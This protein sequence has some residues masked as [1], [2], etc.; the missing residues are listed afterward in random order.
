MNKKLLTLLTLTFLFSISS[1]ALAFSDTEGHWAE[2]AIV[3]AEKMNI[4]NGYSDDTFKPDEP[5]TRAELVAVINRL[6]VI[7]SETDKYVPDVTR[8]DWFH[9]D[10]RK[11]MTMG[12]IQG[13][14]SGFVNPNSYVTREQAALIMAR[15][16]SVVPNN[17]VVSISFTDEADI[18]GWAKS[19]LLNF[20]KKHYITGYPDNTLRPKA[21]ITR[22]EI[23]S[24][25]NRIISASA[26]SVNVDRKLNG[27]IL[28]REKNVSLRNVEVFGDLIVGESAAESLAVV[29]SIVNGNLVLYA[30]IDLENNAVDVKGKIIKIYEKRITSNIRYIDEVYGVDFPLPDGAKVK[31]IDEVNNSD[32]ASNDLIIVDIKQN[33]DYY[34]QT[35]TQIS[36][37]EIKNQVYDSIYRKVETGTFESYQYELYKDNAKSSLLIIKRDNIVYTLLFA[38][39]V[40][41]NILDNVM[42]NIKFIDGEKVIDHSEKIYKNSKLCLK[43]TYKDG[44][45][46]VDDSYNTDVVY[47]GE[48][49]FKLFI[50]VNMITDIDEYSIEEVTALLKTLIKSDGQIVDEEISKISNHDRIQFEIVS[51]DDKIISTY[52]IVGNNLYNFIFKGDKDKM[53]AIGKDMFAEI[54]NSMEF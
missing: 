25:L 33:D 37:A 8:Q 15:A 45:V 10:I 12:I 3:N 5:M 40:S 26:S 18:S 22:A 14:E 17:Q 24:I 19:E 27:N 28:V 2:E 50:Q 23:L 11:A 47:N 20:I 54:V 32:Y 16:F 41:E 44:Y 31:N 42:S 53:D 29:N 52:V 30:P 51:E 6:L 34:F 9:S 36:E 21:N 49:F 39:I 7:E 38:N 48:A 46:G 4:I 13:D 43:F 1:H 35:I